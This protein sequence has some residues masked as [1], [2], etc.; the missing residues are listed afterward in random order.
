MGYPLPELAK[1]LTRMP[2]ITG[3]SQPAERQACCL[4]QEELLPL[5]STDLTA[6][7]KSRNS[8]KS[9]P[10]I[11]HRRKDLRAR[12]TATN[13]RFK[14]TCPFTISGEKLIT[15]AIPVSDVQ[16][17]LLF[18]TLQC[19]YPSHVYFVNKTPIEFPELFQHR[20]LFL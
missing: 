2:F 16:R 19:L 5:D 6:L 12:S 4:F 14:K 9:I 8:D 3:N 10:G 1:P 13:K 15:L 20:G 7:S 17:K 18:F 11:K